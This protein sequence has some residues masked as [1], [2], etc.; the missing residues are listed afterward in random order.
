MDLA[1]TLT[2]SLQVQCDR[3]LAYFSLPVQYNG[4]L[5]IRFSE[6]PKEPDEEVIF[7]SPEDYQL[8]L[9]HYFYECLSL[10]IPIRKIHPD[11]PNGEPGCDP[12]MLRRL[13]QYLVE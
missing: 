12:E 11:L 5:V 9:A 1:I 13:D 2:G 3:C 4:H 6:T 10:S 8:N 7:L